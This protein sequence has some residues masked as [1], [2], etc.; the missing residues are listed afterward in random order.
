[1]CKEAAPTSEDAPI[2]D[3]ARCAAVDMLRF[4][5]EFR[6]TPGSLSRLSAAGPCQRVGKVRRADHVMRCA[7]D[8]PVPH[9]TF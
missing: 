6:L 2:L 7:G 3:I 4:A 8:G 1:M 5:A 9:L